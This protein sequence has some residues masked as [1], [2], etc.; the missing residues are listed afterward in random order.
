[1]TCR[2]RTE[3]FD[4]NIFA[5][6]NCTIRRSR[7]NESTSLSFSSISSLQKPVCRRQSPSYHR[8]FLSMV[9]DR[10]VYAGRSLPL[11]ESMKSKCIFGRDSAS[12]LYSVFCSASRAYGHFY[13]EVY[14]FR[15][16]CS[17]SVPAVLWTFTLVHYFR[18]YCLQ[19]CQPVWSFF[20]AHLLKET[21]TLS[22]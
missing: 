1:M 5:G 12:E 7:M 9:I 18:A 11:M 6:P 3:H 14:R 22:F 20:L 10:S 21:L 16:L 8:L 4:K 2:I 17:S 13:W 19:V 15:S